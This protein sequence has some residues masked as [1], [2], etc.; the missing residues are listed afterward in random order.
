MGKFYLLVLGLVWSGGLITA[1]TF[2]YVDLGPNKDF[3][4]T[5]FAGTAAGLGLS[6]PKNQASDEDAKPRVDPDDPT[7][8]P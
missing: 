5:V 7:T 4:K 1:E 3:F 8:W 2:K 6:R